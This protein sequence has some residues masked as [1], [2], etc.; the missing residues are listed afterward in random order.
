MTFK[1]P[2]V[3]YIGNATHI[4]QLKMATSVLHFCPHD[5]VGVIAAPTA[6]VELDVTYVTL[7]Q[8]KALGAQS[9]VIGMANN[10]GYIQSN[11]ISDIVQAIKLQF[12]I[13]SGMHEKLDDIYCEKNKKTLA[14]LAMKHQVT[15]HNIRHPKQGI[16]VGTG[17][18]RQGKRLL[19]VGTDC[20]SGK[21]FTALYLHNQLQ[22][23]QKQSQ[24]VA[25]GQC[26]IL[27]AGTGIAIDAVAADFISGAIESLTPAAQE[28]TII[29]GQGS[30]FHPAY[31]GVSLGLLHGAQPDYL[32]LCHDMSR[33]RLKNF[34][35]PVPT[36]KDCIKLN[37]AMAKLTNPNCE[38]IGIS[39]NTAT[40]TTTQAKQQIELLSK[41]YKL[42]VTDPYRF[43]VDVF[44]QRLNQIGVI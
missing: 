32:I 39:L 9:M 34:D 18:K 33:K 30:L 38:C 4:N 1:K 41:Q 10:G 26:G 24:F 35:Y 15:L 23:N 16:P 11:W 21:M 37:V 27:I 7:Q 22:V 31:A 28:L 19:T 20:S 14:D 2:Y 44:F 29:E 43:G 3:V 36:I 8:A 17:K 5:C 12:D 6:R 13:I 42:P 40:L 25:T